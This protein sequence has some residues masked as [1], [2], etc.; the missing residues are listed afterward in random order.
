[1]RVRA[2]P[3]AIAL[4]LILGAAG[5][6]GGDDDGTPEDALESYLSALADGD[7]EAAC[8]LLGTEAA[9][10]SM[11]QPDCESDDPTVPDE[12]VEFGDAEVSNVEESGG[13]ATADVTPAD[14]GDPQ[15][16]DLV[17]EDGAWRVDGFAI[18]DV[19]I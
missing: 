3:A 13:E 8:E 17:E 5:C 11:P 2:A 19:E 1:M 6:G 10:T 12:A 14:G 16:V 9:D 7:A 15:T 18:A 4:A